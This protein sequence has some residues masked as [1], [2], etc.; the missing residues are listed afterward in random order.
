MEKGI[1]LAHANKHL[2]KWTGNTLHNK[3]AR[4]NSV[5]TMECSM[6]LHMDKGGSIVGSKYEMRAR[7]KADLAKGTSFEAIKNNT[8]RLQARLGC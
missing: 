2:L 3:N 4:M 1:W 5:T 8:L 7:N 6:T